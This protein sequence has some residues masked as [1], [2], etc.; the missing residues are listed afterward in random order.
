LI[1][2]QLLVTLP[3]IGSPHQVVS[4]LFW[5]GNQQK[6]IGIMLRAEIKAKEWG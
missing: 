4:D 1:P 5:F 2:K 6:P 3:P